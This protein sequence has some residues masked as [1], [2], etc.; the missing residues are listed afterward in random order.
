[1]GTIRTEKRHKANAGAVSDAGLKVA[2]LVTIWLKAITHQK[3]HVHL[4][5]RLV[6]SGA[7]T[8]AAKA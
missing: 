7:P 8:I 3:R 4:T 1:M 2:D 5:I 6:R